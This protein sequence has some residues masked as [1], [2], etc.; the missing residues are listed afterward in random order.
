MG[1]ISDLFPGL[2]P[3]P[4]RDYS[5]EDVIKSSMAEM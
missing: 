5:F 3:P 1:L 4:K 2:D